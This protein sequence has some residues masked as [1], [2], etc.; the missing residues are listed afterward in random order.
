MSKLSSDV[1]Y[2]LQ[3]Q[4]IEKKIAQRFTNFFIVIIFFEFVYLLRQINIADRGGS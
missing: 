1:L 4:K 2:L 3:T